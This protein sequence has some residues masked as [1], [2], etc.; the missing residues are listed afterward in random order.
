MGTQ[1]VTQWDANGNPL[2]P[3]KPRIAHAPTMWDA[4]GNPIEPTQSPL[5][6]PDQ[7][8]D[9]WKAGVYANMTDV[10][11]G[12]AYQNIK[13]FNEQLR[14]AGGDD[15]DKGI[16]YAV[17]TG[18]E[19][20][21]LGM[22]IRGQAPEPFESHDILGNFVHD[23]VSMASDPVFLIPTLIGTA[24]GAPEIGFLVGSAL[25]AGLREGLMDHY[26][27]GDVQDFGELAE[28]AGD[29]L[30]AATKGGLTGEAA[31]LAG[32]LPVGKILGKSVLTSY[33]MKG[34]Y[35]SAAMTAAGSL[36]NGHIP[37]AEDFARSAA[38]MVT[39]NLATGGLVLKKGEAKLALMDGYAK[40][41]TPPLMAEEKLAAQPHV[42]PDQ[43]PGL[44][45][46][47]EM[48]DAFVEGDAGET[49]PELAERI[50]G[51]PPVSMD[52]LEANPELA[53][54][55]LQ[56][57]SIHLQEVIDRAWQ[58]KKEQIERTGTEETALT[59]TGPEL[60]VKDVRLVSGIGPE[61]T[62]LRIDMEGPPKGTTGAEFAEQLF[63]DQVGD[64]RES[65]LLKRGPL[66][67]PVLGSN[68]LEIEFKDAASAQ[69]AMD[70]ISG[71]AK[72]P[73][74]QASLK[75]PS[76]PPKSS[77][78]F[79]TPDGKFLTRAEAAKWVEE[80]E[81][82]V[83]KMWQRIA[84]EKAEF[85]AD[86]YKQARERVLN[87]SAV[88]GEPDLDTASPLERRRLAAVRDD[89]NK[90]KAGSV[91]VKY[92]KS[93]LRTLFVGQRDTRIAIASQLRDTIQKLIPDFRDQ[94]AL[95]FLR[96]Y[97][98]KEA[99]ELAAELEK[100]KAGD[101][102]SLKALIPSIERA[103]NPTPQLLEA[104][105][106]MTDYYTKALSEGREL[107]FLE[108]GIPPDRYVTHVLMR[109]AEEG[110]PGRVGRPK[111]STKTPYAIKRTYPTI[112]DALATGRVEARTLNALDALA[113]YADRHAVA[114]A[115]KLTMMELKNSE[116][117]K[118]GSRE[119]HPAGWRELAPQ[120]P[121]FHQQILIKSADTGESFTLSRGL[122]VPKVVADA[123]RPILE[124]NVLSDI[125]GFRFIR[126][127]QSYIKAVELGLSV[128]HMKALSITGFNN[129]TFGQFVKTLKSD[130]SSP[131]FA[132]MERQAA[133]DGLTT[134][135]TST[136]YEAYQG[137]KPSSIPSRLD[138]IRGTFPLK[139][140]DAL[141]QKLTYE[142]FDVI[143]RKFK[144][145]DYSLKTA[146]WMAKHPDATDAELF[147]ARRSLAKEVNAAYGGLNWE[148]MGWGKNAQELV[149]AFILAPDWTFSN[150]ANLRYAF[151]GGPGGAAARMFWIKSFS[152]GIAMSQGA[153]L[154]ISGQLSKHP[155]EVYLGKDKNGKEVY[156]NWFFAGAP[157]DS[158]TWMSRVQKDGAI[159]GTA[160]FLTFK[161]G[162]IA[163][164]LLGLVENREFS[165][166][167]ITK[168]SQGTAEKTARELGFVGERLLPVPFS[169]SNVARMMMDPDKE[170]SY[171]DYLTVLGG[172]PPRHEGEKGE[173][174][175]KSTL[176]LS[177]GS[178]KTKR[179]Y[180]IR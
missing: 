114:A 22:L 98:G 57:P 27:K 53:D 45:P 124:R 102:E 133:A 90:I 7:A 161:L 26:Q 103:L 41:G 44:K 147:S 9:I 141:A 46:A 39:L 15:F 154:L 106:L 84:G 94:E 63:P 31:L 49:H 97:R 68:V 42:P 169:V 126:R 74:S 89:L 149:R 1:T 86:D 176:Q 105:R 35:Q 64:I 144:V 4:S 72:Q 160:E 123:M 13:Q 30:W 109:S 113:V 167:P 43:N 54:E 164:T 104:D 121:G 76:E 93:V 128:F 178:K 60:N 92:A 66:F 51:K 56:N 155:T 157:K 134:A 91:S 129:E 118:F 40:T 116:L 171:M 170:Y 55:V 180:S 77:R 88:E 120:T 19:D 101:D 52:R 2:E 145:M 136:P 33:A 16:G 122:Y 65:R 95:S 165:G 34:L 168:P 107:G 153:S 75:A 115:T 85:H 130:I 143:Q 110:E 162:P 3:T 172:S 112:L 138:V 117:G 8:S 32:G 177:G 83:F 99:G 11:P 166:K 70:Q 173:T 131:E 59:K 24:V 12:Y 156:A 142:T 36:L 111:I 175:K 81:P 108:S 23:I 80:N 50:M 174:P 152:T 79:V 151:E 38:V 73:E 158:I 137:L 139:Q 67:G 135:K 14:A 71:A 29:I 125:P 69:R 159:T 87:R 119:D 78:G 61:K 132:E 179:R 150:V 146:E 48:G 17:E 96:D 62:L 10:D 6:T 163:G 58:L 25:D 20:T 37:R 82:E 47:I 21:P 140:V 28:R 100:I 148:V 127:A 5:L 18:W